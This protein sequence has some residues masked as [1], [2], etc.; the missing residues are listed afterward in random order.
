MAYTFRC[1]LCA[2]AEM[3]SKRGR[4]EANQD[5]DVPGGKRLR[6]QVV[7]I[8]SSNIISGSQAQ[9]M[10]DAAADAG[11]Q[12]F[13]DLAN[14]RPQQNPGKHAAR[15]LRRRL[16]RGRAWP[17]IY[18]AEITTWST[19]KN[20][21]V[22]SWVSFAPP[23]AILGMLAAWGGGTVDLFDKTQ[24]DPLTSAH[25]EQSTSKM[26]QDLP[27]LGVG[28]WV[29]AVPCNWDRTESIEVWPWGQQ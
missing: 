7:D 9:E 27:W 26:P 25:F 1:L 16:L 4:P 19:K 6:G 17:S 2:V 20:R 28:L 10:A 24:M 3:L 29:D 8:F 12:E 21:N 18:K 11:V 15:N 13:E 5:R 23:H 14:T 22:Q